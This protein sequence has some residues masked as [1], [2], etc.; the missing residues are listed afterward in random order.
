MAAL[1]CLILDTVNMPQG[2]QELLGC[3]FVPFL[4][5]VERLT[6]ILFSMWAFFLF[7]PSCRRCMCCCFSCA[8]LSYSL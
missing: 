2:V 4:A 3:L 7:R 1:E 5:R 8:F 6:C